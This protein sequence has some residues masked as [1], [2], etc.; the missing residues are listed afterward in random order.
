MTSSGMELLD[1]LRESSSTEPTPVVGQDRFDVQRR[2][3]S[4]FAQGVKA[5]KGVWVYNG[6]MWHG[7]SFD[8]VSALAGPKALTAYLAC[9][10]TDAYA[11][12]EDLDEMY[13]FRPDAVFPDLT[14]LDNDFYVCHH[15]MEWTMAFTHEQPTIG[16]FYAE[17]AQQADTADGLTAATDP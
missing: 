13:R 10:S 8:L 16:P 9:Y 5:V 1:I 3:L 11:F 17:A 14:E 7:F 12:D 6:Y 15:N 4:V 2:W